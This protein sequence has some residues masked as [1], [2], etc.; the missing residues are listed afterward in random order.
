MTP[1]NPYTCPLTGVNLVEASAGTGKTYNIQNL[2][3]RLIVEEDL[4]VDQILVVTFTETATKELRDRLRKILADLVAPSPGDPQRVKNLLKSDSGPAALRGRCR[5]ARALRDFDEAA[6]F[7]IHGFCQRVLAENA[8]ESGIRFNLQLE[9]NPEALIDDIIHDFY[10]NTFYGMDESALA[11]CEA[12]GVTLANMRTFINE[13]QRHAAVTVL[14]R[15]KGFSSTVI[16]ARLAALKPLWNRDDVI[17]Q[18]A[19]A[20][21]KAGPYKASL[22][23]EYCDAVEKLFAGDWSKPT[24]DQARML[25]L[26]TMTENA[27]KKSSDVTRITAPFFDAVSDWFA[28]WADAVGIYND[29]RDYFNREYPKRKRQLGIQTFNDLLNNVH[30]RVTGGDESLIQ[31]M[32]G[33]YKA[34][35]IDEFQDTDPVQWGIFKTVFA[36]AGAPVFMVGDPKQ[37]I[38]G[39]R[40]GDIHTYKQAKRD[41]GS[42]YT[43]GVNYRSAPD[44]V[45]AAND[46][47]QT[48]GDTFFDPTIPFEPV[49]AREMSPGTGLRLNGRSLT[50]PLKLIENDHARPPNATDLTVWCGEQT[51][52][53]IARM[54]LPA[55]SAESLAASLVEEVDG[56]LVERPLEPRDFAVLVN[57][58]A[59]AVHMKEV[60]RRFTIP[61]VVKY[62][63]AI[64]GSP[65]ATAFRHL[66]RVMMNPSDLKNLRGC[67]AGDF[68]HLDAGTLARYND[69]SIG[70]GDHQRDEAAADFSDWVAFFKEL[71][72]VWEKHGFIGM[73]NTMLRRK[74][75]RATLLKQEGGERKLT[76][77]LHLAELVH[78]REQ[79]RGG[80][81]EGVLAWL[82]RQAETPDGDGEAEIRLESDDDAVTIMTIYKSKGLE[83]NVVFCPFLWTQNAVR[84]TKPT[85]TLFHDER[86]GQTL[87]LL[88]NPDNVTRR[89]VEALRENMRL[90]YVAVTRAKYHCAL[91]GGKSTVKHP[92]SS[93]DYMFRRGLCLNS[94]GVT[95]AE[96]A[97]DDFIYPPDMRS[98]VEDTR[99]HD[100]DWLAA[101]RHAPSAPTGE[102][103]A[104]VFDRTLIDD[105]WRVTSFSSLQPGR[106]G[107]PAE[108]LDKDHDQ[109]DN[110]E[111]PP[112]VEAGGQLTIFTFPAGARTGTCWHEIF[113]SL[114]FQADGD[115]IQEAVRRSLEKYKL[116][117]GGTSK[118]R[119]W[120]RDIVEEMVRQVLKADLNG[121]TFRDISMADRLSELEFNFTLE[122][123]FKTTDLTAVLS[124][125]IRPM[126]G[127]GLGEWNETLT[128]GMMNGFIDLVFRHQGAYYI[129]DWKS[130]RLN[131]QADDFDEAGMLAEIAHHHYYLQYLIY[132]VAL[133]RFLRSRIPDYHYDRHVGGVYYI[134]LRGVNSENNNGVFFTRPDRALIETLEH[135]L[136]VNAPHS[137][138][139]V[140]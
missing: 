25:T 6:I 127:V 122:N 74:N 63:G 105:N 71:G 89:N 12:R 61:A 55:E 10:R 108:A 30:L 128:G 7:T 20:D 91:L 39:F 59:Q 70:A 16:R 37:A 13:K 84:G 65:E 114:D 94:L 15:E 120:K 135:T 81:P 60:L 83:F 124:D 88:N 68:F 139:S 23:T 19:L 93:L 137:R 45:T 27:T 51:A 112:G 17:Q 58:N 76:N 32:R 49:R 113:E 46:L 64:F 22:V 136:C 50:P 123:G 72:Q 78:Q 103:R 9:P 34:L 111:P 29:L 54:L 80:G 125:Y 100:K 8:F 33:R 102:L 92:S 140:T 44:M 95:A 129:T 106:S 52:T 5:A 101:L 56:Q 90:A 47:F 115:T 117:T 79:T 126:F 21:L 96:P 75:V 14:Q 62:A 67:L 11:M 53:R 57:T 4:T 35:I 121:F 118:E 40:G 43:L 73:F 119:Q 109:D 69:Q 87:D 38:Y 86:A 26:E 36:R 28:A 99:F 1:L 3:A 116:D 133:H 31:A 18:V 24:V 41:A 130:N 48:V 77:L 82:E 107:T 66:L 2:F 132:T 131:G 97:T 98:P 104:A 138:N 110:A 42:T 134:F 85:F